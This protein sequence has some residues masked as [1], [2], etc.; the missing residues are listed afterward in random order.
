[1]MNT[2]ATNTRIPQEGIGICYE[3]KP[4]PDS[5]NDAIRMTLIE[6]AV[7]PD[8]IPREPIPSI[9]EPGAPACSFDL[10]GALPGMEGGPK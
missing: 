9:P 10:K 6:A 1:M 4:V 7:R 8:L 5:V 3:L 2:T